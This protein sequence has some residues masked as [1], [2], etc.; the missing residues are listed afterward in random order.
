M[1]AQSLAV[2]LCF[3]VAGCHLS[4]YRTARS[5]ARS[6]VIREPPP[7]PVD[8]DKVVDE[9]SAPAEPVVHNNPNTES[10]VEPPIVYS[11]GSDGAVVVQ[12]ADDTTPED[13]AEEHI[14]VGPSDTAE[15]ALK[16]ATTSTSSGDMPEPMPE[17]D[18]AW[19]STYLPGHS[20]LPGTPETAPPAG[21][22]AV[23]TMVP[24]GAAAMSGSAAVVLHDGAP[25]LQMTFEGL[26]RGVYGISVDHASCGRF[27]PEYA[28]TPSVSD[29]SSAQASAIVKIQVSDQGRVSFHARIPRE[30]LRSRECR[31]LVI[32]E[33]EANPMLGDP[34]GRVAAGL[35]VFAGSE[36]SE[37]RARS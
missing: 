11:M 24:V 9:R 5:G 12:P 27:R 1:R 17:D 3:V 20:G 19:V 30:R 33:L 32:R 10:K 23:A 15:P 28:V 37:T 14:M 36:P 31:W 21:A 18:L 26:G 34:D 35:L 6:R 22:I 25:E 16:P 4:V 29:R 7:T 13:P 8:E 2:L